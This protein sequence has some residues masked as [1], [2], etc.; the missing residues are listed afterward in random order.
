MS[1]RLFY[2]SWPR[3]SC[4]YVLLTVFSCVWCAFLRLWFVQHNRDWAAKTMLHIAEGSV[5][6]LFADL[7]MAC[8]I[9]M[10]YQK[11][12]LSLL[13]RC[14]RGL[15]RNVTRTLGEKPALI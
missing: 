4:I 13:P 12:F 7:F 8:S 6:T 3:L 1:C 10:S 15:W 11:Y 2:S 14:P 5:R 9:S